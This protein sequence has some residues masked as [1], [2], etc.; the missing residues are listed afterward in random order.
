MKKLLHLLLIPIAGIWFQSVAAGQSLPITGVVTASTDGQ[1]LPGVNVVIKGSTQ[2]TTTSAA[3]TFS[4]EAGKEHVL[5]FSF[6]GY[7][8]Q[9]VLVGNQTTLTVVLVED[10]TTLSEVAVFATGYEQLPKE[11]ATGSFVHADHEL[12]N[13]RVSTN[14]LDRLEDV[15]S[16]V[17]FNR[18]G[19]ASDAISIRGRSTLFANANPLIV[20][21]NFPY[22][23]DLSN[24]NPN[25]VESITVL[26]DAAAASIW[27]ARAGNGVI[28]ITT[29][30]GTKTGPEVSFSANITAGEKNDAFYLP[31]MTTADYIDTEVQLFEGGYYTAL[32]NS[33]NKRA[34]TPVVELLIAERAGDITTEELHAT[35]AAWKQRDV[36]QDFDRYFYQ[37][38]VNQQ[39]AVNLRGGTGKQHYVLGAGYDHN[40]GNLVGNSYGRVTLNMKN[41]WMLLSDKLS[42]TSELY[43]TRST[44]SENGIDPGTLRMT[45]YDNLY[46][47][48]QLADAGG[49]PL[50]IVQDYREGFK[51]DAEAS[52]LLNW[53]YKPLAERDA[54]HKTI[55][56]SDYRINT[57]LRYTVMP[58]LTAEA[59]YQ[60]WSSANDGRQHYSPESY[61]VRNLINQYTQTNTGKLTHPI[62]HG[63]IL[64]EHFQTDLSHNFRVQLNYHK[65]FDNHAIHGL[66]GYEV[67]EVNTT[68]SQYRHYGYNDELARSTPVDYGTLY[69][70]YYYPFSTARIP[71]VD[72]HLSLTDRFVSYYGNAG[73]TYRNRYTLTLSARKDQSN[74]FGVDANQR[75]VP[76][77]STGTLWTVSDEP[78]YQVG[79][80]PLLKLRVTYGYSGNIDKTVTAYTT[81]QTYGTNSTTG[82]PYARIM[83]P[84]NPALQWEKI[85]MINVGIDVELF[86]GNIAGSIEYYQKHGESLIG[87]VPVAPSTG[88]SRFKGN[89]SAT[90]SHGVDLVLNTKNINRKFTWHT[91]FLL[92]T[93]HLKV[94]NYQDEA[95]ALYLVNYG[96]IGNYVKE[97]HTLFGVYSYRWAGLDPTTGDP[98]GYLEGG[99]SKDYTRIINEATPDDLEYHGAARPT[100]FGAVRN[101]FSWHNFSFSFNISYR[102]GYYFRTKSIVYGNNLGLGGHGDYYKRWQQPGDENSTHVPAIPAG[103][104]ANR[105]QFYT[106]SAALV[107][108]GDHIRLQ[109]IQ[110]SYTMPSS[111]KVFPFKR[112]QV[113]AYINNIGL[114]WK[115]TDQAKDPDYA[116]LPP[117]RT[118]AIGLKIDF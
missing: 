95:P 46:P 96:D 40:V 4:I 87:F 25:D 86:K 5:V 101:T 75:G 47:Y 80:M 44:T 50:A 15:A 108:K 114:L 57:A 48:A 7:T 38:P 28:V 14:I 19:S 107:E 49:E 76:L 27:G 116:V 99:V 66:A 106:Y 118:Y 41:N 17:I 90:R 16:G 3:G 91:Q 62:P 12:L 102:F 39:Y 112:A 109:D 37:H 35:L 93:N 24:I 32:E 55:K 2:G 115:A 52:G 82:L 8:P 83:N 68:G 51:R 56:Q 110:L 61:F 6:I 11:R 103:I 42:L 22:D 29:K 1:P 53:A 98:Q 71:N 89:N 78:F 64:D 10:I 18:S 54:I 20:I 74:L 21:D 23:G 113:Y 36:R 69:S 104:V 81:A 63:G 85:R 73:Y 30:K 92:S 60:F 111:T 97:G 59:L 33:Y 26:K 88:V 45:V 9:E 94:T 100:T 79:F 13:R 84:P 67:K 65:T 70:Q 34:L 105:D 58:W 72:Q 31:V 43:F 77:W 117:V